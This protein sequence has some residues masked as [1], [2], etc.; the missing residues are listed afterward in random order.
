VKKGYWVVTYRSISDEAALQEYGKLA[1][2]AIAAHG[3]KSIIRTSSIAEV[4]EAGLKQRVTI[5]EFPS[6]SVAIAARKSDAYQKA[7][8]VLGSAAERDVRIGEG[9]D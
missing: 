1:S 7:L 6:V 3:G 2:A 9:V 8:Q 5:T 4:H